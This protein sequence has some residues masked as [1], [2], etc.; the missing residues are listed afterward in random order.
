VRGHRSVRRAAVAT[1]ALAA[2]LGGSPARAGG[3]EDFTQAARRLSKALPTKDEKV[4]ADAVFGL[5]FFDTP[6]AARL[7]LRTAG[8]EAPDL[9][10]DAARDCLRRFSSKEATDVV[11]QEWRSAPT[12]RRPYLVEVLGA[13]PDRRVEEVLAAAAEEKDPQRR[14][15][16]VRALAGRPKPGAAARGALLDAAGDPDPRVRSAA[17]HGLSLLPGVDAAPAL[18]G[19]MRAETGRLFG[20]AWLGLRRI[21]GEPLAP[22]LERCEAWWKTQPG[23]DVFKPTDAGRPALEPSLRLAGLLSWSRRI[24]FVLD[25]SEGMADK[26]GY[27]PEDLMPPAARELRGRAREDWAT[28]AT[29][30]DHA[31]NLLSLA[32]ETLP[33]D[34]AFDVVFGAESVNAVFRRPERA[35]PE[36]KG[37]AL[38]RLR[39]LGARGRQDLHALLRTAMAEPALDPLDPEAFLEGADTVVYLGTALPSFGT[40]ADTGRIL[41]ALHRADR[42]RQV[43]FLSVGVGNHGGDFL[44]NLA[45]IPPGGAHAAVP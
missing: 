6:L 1:L 43:S 27:R 24:V 39:G 42:T 2:L 33:A 36:A 14:T 37:R 10:L 28:M 35:T 22:S 30:L 40:V 41:S 17:L 5:R 44:E 45:Q 38:G 12:D 21:S 8:R 9:V 11:L 19:R 29:R 25:L 34:C 16:V 3:E 13:M 20:D 15:A 31:R 7:A 23:T 18:L 32:I 26:P 4:I